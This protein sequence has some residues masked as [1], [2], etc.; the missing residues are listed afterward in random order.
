[1][2]PGDVIA[3]RFEVIE[4]VGAGG[5]GVVFRGRDR[6]TGHK[7][8]IKVLRERDEISA[9]RF[10][11]EARVLAEIRHP[12]IVRYISHGTTLGGEQYLAMEWLTGESLADRLR[13]GPLSVRE[14]LAVASRAADALGAAHA[15][16]VVHRDVKPSNLW[17]AGGAVERLKVLDFGVARRGLHASDNTPHG[18]RVGTPR[19]MA[20]EQV[21]G[22]NVD[23]RA[24]VFALGS[25]LYAALTGRNAFIGNDEM[26]VL[27]KILLEEP[28]PVRRLRPEVPAPLAALVARMLA[29]D[30]AARPSDGNAVA[31]ELAALPD[32]ARASVTGELAVP[33]PERR[34]MT[35]VLTAR[36]RGHGPEI[37]LAAARAVAARHGAALLP[38]H[39]GFVAVVSGQRSAT[40]Q[41]AQAAWVAL[42]LLPLVAEGPIA[43]ATGMG[44][45]PA[46]LP[47]GEVIDRAARL[48]GS[49][50]GR[51]IVLDEVTSG[52]LDERFEV[53]GG[54]LHGERDQPAEA[55]TVLG[56]PTPYV[57]RE[58]EL[59]LLETVFAECVSDATAHAVLVTGP[60]G[61]GKSRL[62]HEFLKRTGGI[63]LLYAR[64]DPMRA[65]S[66]FSLVAPA[67]R[68][69]AGV[70]PGD[71]AELQRRALAARVGERVAPADAGRV[72]H[73]LGELVGLPFAVDDDVQLRAA[74]QDAVLMGDQMRRAWEDF[75]LAETAARPVLLVFEDLHWGDLPSAHLVDAALRNLAHRPLMVLALARPEVRTHFPNL[76][77]E[78]SMTELRLGELGRK[79]AERLVRAVLPDV[80]ADTL[81]RVV[82]VAHGNAFYLEELIR[83]VAGGKT[84]GLPDT[85]LAMVQSRL[86]AFSPEARRILRAAAIFGGTFWAGGVAAILGDAGDLAEWLP[87]LIEREM[88]VARR[89]SRIPGESEL[90]FRHTLVREG[91]YAAWGDAE[92]E[93]AHRAAGDWLEARGEV[94]PILLAEHFRRGGEPRRAVVWY[95]RAAEQDLEGNDF[96]GAI[97][98]VERGIACG[99]DDPMRIE[100]LLLAIEAHRWRGENESRAQRCREVLALSVPGDRAWCA[101][102][103]ELITTAVKLGD[104]DTCSRLAAELA[105]LP[106][107]ASAPLWIA[108]A[109]AV[110]ALLLLGMV[111]EADRLLGRLDAPAETRALLGPVVEAAVDGSRGVRA[112]VDGDLA[113]YLRLYQSSVAALELAGDQRRAIGARSNLGFGLIEVGAYPDAEVILRANGIASERLGQES[114]KGAALQNLG[115]ALA[116]QGRLDEAREVEE[117][118]V[119]LFERQGAPYQEGNSRIYLAR[120]LSL[121][122]DAAGAAAEAR[123]AL[124]LLG[125][126]P[127]LR[128]FGLA[129]LAG[130]LL[131]QGDPAAALVAAEESIGI[132][133]ARGEISEG[134]SFVRLTWAT[135]LAAAGRRDDAASARATAR[136]RLT[137]RANR[138]SDA[139]LRE[140]FLTRVPEN[141]ATMA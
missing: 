132:L 41:A 27:A 67:V 113:A 112:L 100:L 1:M 118:A 115:W 8:A 12:G 35:V 88:I 85:V 111:A 80:A 53:H 5:M 20:P 133:G 23:A 69:V 98:R 34:L 60:P 141:A 37:D 94:D 121:I 137:E 42:A 44:A 117:Q 108:S 49:A 55:R 65:G 134:E 18:G 110:T 47:V 15:A 72:A 78:R 130:A 93:R 122:G 87:V 86:E 7:V 31:A 33:E 97:D 99:A 96:E 77:G 73:F 48:L 104:R 74:R 19:Y 54:V 45:T 129:V 140:R 123:R 51:I 64:G 57:G 114:S 70:R 25:V 83:A 84:D 135:V 89:E 10:F 128:C 63:T 81:A 105:A 14:A 68:R 127:P 95:R 17:L 79:A 13:R 43:V 6:H 90:A 52:L 40:D 138:M 119:A 58:R 24:D 3:D 9:A 39:G 4:L 76:W 22:E 29:K 124:A 62:C 59:A 92:R 2:R 75:L 107:Q 103:G 120:I 28:P 116:R 66:P 61:V 131:A 139:A 136:A 36:P 109:R 106:A 32:A 16:G 26:A 11:L 50:G 91:A 71:P 82:D 126:A 56:K 125:A 30:A 38:M 101:A 21:R 46:L 102:A